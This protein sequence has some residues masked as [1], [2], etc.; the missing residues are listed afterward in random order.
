[1]PE[2]STTTDQVELVRSAIEAAKRRD[3]DAMVAD[4][5]PDAVWDLSA[6]GLE[7]F[8]GRAAIRAHF[9]DWFAPHEELDWEV[10]EIRDLGNGIALSVA[11]ELARM[12]GGSA[13]MSRHIAFVWQFGNGL[14]VRVAPYSD[15]D[16]A[17]ADA[18]RL[19]ASRW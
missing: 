18:E 14:I 17:R 13:V 15:V 12:R 3:V 11:H 2:R 16:Q 6:L 9:V 10:E 19:A 1:M 7:T 8:K 4:Y 5:A